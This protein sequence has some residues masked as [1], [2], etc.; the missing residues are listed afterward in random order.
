MAPDLARI[1]TAPVSSNLRLKSTKLTASAGA[2]LDQLRKK[3]DSQQREIAQLEAQNTSL[4]KALEAEKLHVTQ[5]RGR[6]EEATGSL[7][8]GVERRRLEAEIAKRD[9]E[10]LELRQLVMR[11]QIG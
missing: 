9:K 10:I 5:L 3:V 8:T 4:R 1:L 2:K 6:L 7:L 11:G